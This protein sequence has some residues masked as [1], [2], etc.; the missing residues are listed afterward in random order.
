MTMIYSILPVRL[1]GHRL[2]LAMSWFWLILSLKETVRWCL[3]ENTSN[4]SN[5]A[6][7]ATVEV[8]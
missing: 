7:L 3:R 8:L 5:F 6:T 1:K 2:S 4:T